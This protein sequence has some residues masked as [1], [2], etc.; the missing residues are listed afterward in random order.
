MRLVLKGIILYFKRSSAFSSPTNWRAQA[1]TEAK[2][3]TAVAIVQRKRAVMTVM[4]MVTRFKCIFA[5]Q[6]ILIRLLVAQTNGAMYF[7][8]L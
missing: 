2:T 1:V 6:G 3:T 8:H 4:S 7:P 5:K